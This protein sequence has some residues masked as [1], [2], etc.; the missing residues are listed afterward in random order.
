MYS[1]WSVLFTEPHESGSSA[2]VR[3]SPCFLKLAGKALLTVA[4]STTTTYI[5]VWTNQS[6]E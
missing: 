6:I 5:G 3:P 4:L 2:S 1:Q